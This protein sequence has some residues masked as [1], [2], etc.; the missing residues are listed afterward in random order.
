M[1]EMK[2]D[3]DGYYQPGTELWP[4]GLISV[5]TVLPPPFNSADI[6]E[7]N[8]KSA[9]RRGSLVHEA[10][11]LMD[12]GT[13]EDG[14]LE[15]SL[16]SW[17]PEDI[18]VIRPYLTGYQRFME[19]T[20]PTY[21]LMESVVCS[22]RHGYAGRLD[23]A[24][25]YD[26]RPTIFDT[27]TGPLSLTEPIQL[28]AYLYAYAEEQSGGW[29]Q[30]QG[31]SIGDYQRISIHL[32]KEGNYSIHRWEG[33]D[34]FE[35]FLSFLRTCRWKRD[36]GFKEARPISEAKPRKSRSK[37][38][39]EEISVLDRPEVASKLDLLEQ[40]KAQKSECEALDKALKNHFE[41]VE[42]VQ[43]GDWLVEGE[44]TERHYKPRPAQD[45]RTTRGWTTRFT[46]TDGFSI[47]NV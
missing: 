35:N 43:V 27:K 44:E 22:H 15:Q 24:G 2:R 46:R 47:G 29:K 36:N 45:A 14:S 1:T 10:T 17:A 23:R 9:S 42:R 12:N 41:G 34:D 11:F 28:S 8:L 7:E 16:P 19:D 5:T 20:A 39:E 32:T 13:M 37:G 40:L 26:G 6:P 4:M 3:R 25:E 21:T 38:M 18:E 30:L 33:K 31:R